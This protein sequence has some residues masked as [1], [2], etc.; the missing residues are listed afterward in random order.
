MT[1]DDAAG[2]RAVREKRLFAADSE[3]VFIVLPRSSMNSKTPR[4][5]VR[6]DAHQRGL[7]AARKALRTSTKS[8]RSTGS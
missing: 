3:S 6:E 4:I 1:I 5:M 8:R 7:T 2:R